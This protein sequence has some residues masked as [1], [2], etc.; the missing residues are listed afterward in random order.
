MDVVSKPLGGLLRVPDL[1]DTCLSV[2][3]QR[4]LI[5][6]HCV[7]REDSVYIFITVHGK[8]TLTRPFNLSD[9][10]TWK[11]A[12]LAIEGSFPPTPFFRASN[13]DDVTLTERKLVL[14]GLLEVEASFNH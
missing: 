14:I 2:K 13:I 12:Y 5:M 7:S 1:W 8:L 3:T 11:P 6:V 4:D 9:I 10:I